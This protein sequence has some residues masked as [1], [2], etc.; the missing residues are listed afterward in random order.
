MES[1]TQ[2]L[3]ASFGFGPVS[4]PITK[5]ELIDLIVSYTKKGNTFLSV[6]QIT[7]FK[8]KTRNVP[9]DEFALTGISNP[10]TAIAKIGQVNG[11]IN[12][13]YEKAVNKERE[14]VGLSTDFVPQE[15][16]GEHITEAV[17]ELNGNYYIQYYPLSVSKEFTPKFIVSKD[18][19]FVEI[20]KE[21]ASQY[22]K[23]YVQPID[24]PKVE[25]RRLSIDSIVGIAIG[26]EQYHVTDIDPSR[27]AI[28]QLFIN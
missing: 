14:K 21:E 2:S 4:K 18:G 17:I 22:K 5:K 28:K 10:K 26:G 20:S 3:S 11:Q 1:N 7:Q 27:D 6:T 9:F 12:T 8:N 25:V 13:N 23:E 19:S 15:T 16:W 24:Q